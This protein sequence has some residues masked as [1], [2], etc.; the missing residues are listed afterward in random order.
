MAAGYGRRLYPI[1]KDYPKPLLS[2]GGHPIIDYIVDKLN[3]TKKINRIIVVTNDKFISYFRHWKR[4]TSC[5]K[6]IKLINDLT[7][8]YEDRLGALGDI[9]FVIRKERLKEDLIIIG[10]DNLFD[11]GLEGFFSYVGKNRLYT[12]VGVYHIKDKSKA[13]RYGVVSINKKKRIID[14]EEKPSKPKSSLIAMCLYYF[15]KDKLSLLREYLNTKCGDHDAAG[16]FINW[17]YRKEKTLAYIFRG[18]WYDIGQYDLYKEAAK[19][20]S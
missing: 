6:Q 15:P 10:G 5:K 8:S 16:S 12:I 13:N 19:F 7:R 2:V 4:K 14:F 3:K 20:F 9:D 11:E 1:T 18:R 17:L